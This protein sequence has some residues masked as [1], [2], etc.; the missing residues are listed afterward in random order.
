MYINDTH[1]GF[2][3]IAAIIPGIIKRKVHKHTKIPIINA[4]AKYSI[5]ILVLEN[6]SFHSTFLL[7]DNSKK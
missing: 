6:N 5:A 2:Y 1:I 3:L 7:R 4:K